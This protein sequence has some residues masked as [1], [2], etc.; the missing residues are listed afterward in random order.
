MSIIKIEPAL[1]VKMLKYTKPKFYDDVI[2]CLTDE[3]DGFLDILRD[4]R[5]VCL[6]RCV[7]KKRSLW[8]N[9]SC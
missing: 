6:Q 7:G 8:R 9:E 5:L 3:I 2:I 4:N 1:C